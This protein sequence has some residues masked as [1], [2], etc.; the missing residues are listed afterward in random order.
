MIKD[1]MGA[2]TF[3]DAIKASEG[4]YKDGPPA[5]NEP[6]GGLATVTVTT[7]AARHIVGSDVFVAENETTLPIALRNPRRERGRRL[8]AS[9]KIM[10]LAPKGEGLDQFAHGMLETKE[11]MVEFLAVG[12]RGALTQNSQ[13]RFCGAVMA[14]AKYS[15]GILA[16]FAVTMVGMFDLPENKSDAGH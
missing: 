7:W 16:G 9:G 1:V 15:T 10:Y 13:A 5:K 12:M 3:A 14:N 11:G 6:G 4:L 8:C 2:K